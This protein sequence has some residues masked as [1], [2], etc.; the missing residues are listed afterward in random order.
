LPTSNLKFSITDGTNTGS[1]IANTTG[2]YFIPVQAG[3]HT[4][5]P[6]L[7]NPNYFSISPTNTVVT[8]PTQTSPFTQDFCVTANGIHPDLEV[9]LLPI[10]RA[11]PG[12]D[13]SYKIIYKNK[14]IKH[15]QVR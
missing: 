11:R 6:I 3:T 12:F 15:N 7:E 10:N 4:I 8:F 5:T 1:V 2:N 13:A 9:T 14:G